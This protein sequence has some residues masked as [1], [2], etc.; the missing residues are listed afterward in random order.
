MQSGAG[1]GWGTLEPWAGEERTQT[2][3]IRQEQ[4]EAK[5]ERCTCDQEAGVRSERHRA[6]PATEPPGGPDPANRPPRFRFLSPEN[7][8]PLCSESRSGWSPLTIAP[9]KQS[10]A[11]S[12]IPGQAELVLASVHRP[13]T[14]EQGAMTRGMWTPPQFKL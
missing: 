2:R 9:G 8:C 14:Q 3:R 6:A 7:K 4:R 11:Y 1:F 13:E 5:S 12:R 10:R